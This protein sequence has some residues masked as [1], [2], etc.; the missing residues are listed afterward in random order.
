ML[1]GCGNK[2]RRVGSEVT[3]SSRRVGPDGLVGGII[4]YVMRTFFALRHIGRVECVTDHVP[5]S[6]SR[7]GAAKEIGDWDFVVYFDAERKETPR[8]VGGPDRL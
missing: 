4:L 1:F 3:S 7:G 5:W 8:L 2:V 6:H